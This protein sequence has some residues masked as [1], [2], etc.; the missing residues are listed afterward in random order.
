MISRGVF[1]TIEGID[2]VGKSTQASLLADRLTEQEIPVVQTR[3]PGGSP[4]GEAIRRLLKSESNKDLSRHTEIL[5]FTAVRRDHLEKVILPALD[6]GK[7]VVCDRF[8][9]S[10]RVYQGR[11]YREIIDQLHEQFIGLNADLTFIL[12]LPESFA[13]ERIRHRSEHDWRLEKAR[14]NTHDG[15]ELFREIAFQ[16]PKRCQLVDA[17]WPEKAVSDLMLSETLKKIP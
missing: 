17:S 3:E 11:E 15:S 9:D 14:T 1:V 2:G 10:T 8:V 6:S 13:T 12:D 5:L 4:C 16:Y 7:V